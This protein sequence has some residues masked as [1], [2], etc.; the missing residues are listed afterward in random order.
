MIISESLIKDLKPCSARFV[1]FC[2]HN[3]NFTGSI[4]DFKKCNNISPEDISWVFS[5]ILNYQQL[6]IEL[7]SDLINIVKGDD[8]NDIKDILDD[9]SIDNI[10]KK[11]S[12]HANRPNVLSQYLAQI[13]IIKWHYSDKTVPIRDASIA[14]YLKNKLIDELSQN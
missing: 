9:H 5:R 12:H 11:Y 1:N 6:I 4:E 3:P 8:L 13:C 2:K 14:F 10:I 7:T